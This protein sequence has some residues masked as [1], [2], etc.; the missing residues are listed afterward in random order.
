[1]C[2]LCQHEFCTGH[3]A[4]FELFD[5]RGHSCGSFMTAELAAGCVRV[6]LKHAPGA[7]PYSLFDFNGNRLRYSVQPQAE[8]DLVF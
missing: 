5:K 3:V 8:L 1:M 6:L 7:E 4:P 2:L